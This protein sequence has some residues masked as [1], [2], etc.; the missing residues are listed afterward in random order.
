MNGLPVSR[1][2][3]L[4]AGL[5]VGGLALA[6]RNLFA[7]TRR[8]TA[9]AFPGPYEEAARR[10]PGALFT[11]Q[12]GAEIGIQ[13]VLAQEAMAKVVASRGNPPYDAV[14]LDEATYLDSLKLDVFEP[15]PAAKMKHLADIASGFGD[16]RNMGAFVAAHVIG[17]AY[18]PKTVK[19]PPTS[20]LDLWKPEFKGRVGITTL[21]S[22]LGMAFLVEIAKL[23]GGSAA[24]MEP[25][26]AAMRKLLPSVAATAP[27][28]GAFAAMFQQGQIDIAY[29][30]LSA[31]EPLRARGV[32]VALTRPKEGFILLRNSMHIVKGS[33]APDL[34]ASYID[35]NL[36]PDV[37]SGMGRLPY[38][39]FP[40]NR[41]VAFSP[42]LVPYAKDQAALSS[43]T[44][45]DWNAI[46]PQRRELIE[47]FNKEIRV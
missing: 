30:F 23:H 24:N 17:I 21:G 29:N 32:D 33:K 13:P 47:R 18:N 42:D 9:T 44:I 46:N 1:R 26:F 10:L 36:D 28:P 16:S 8:I 40:T 25:A 5:A 27:N 37:Q 22:G 11:R 4:S 43:N 41:K 2:A 15:L 7:Q 6:N 38:M 31:I 35:A 45:T 19:T 14:I 20:W 39:V 34:A 12:T 3:V